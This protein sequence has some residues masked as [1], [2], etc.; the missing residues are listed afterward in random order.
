MMGGMGINSVEALKGNRLMLRG[1]DLNEKSL[2]YSAYS[3][4]V[5]DKG[6]VK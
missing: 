2:R 3:T 5:S 1:I 6:E 4:Q